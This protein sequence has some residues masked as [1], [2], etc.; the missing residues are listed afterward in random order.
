FQA[1]RALRKRLADEQRVPPFVIFGDATLAEMAACRPQDME[2]MSR[3]GG[4]GKF[5]LGRYGA[6]FL[7]VIREFRRET[8]DFD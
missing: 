8:A 3:I 5:K 7:H 4:V 1:L 6:E 2:E